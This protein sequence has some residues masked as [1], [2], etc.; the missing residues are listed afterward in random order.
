M[1]LGL[2][3]TEFNLNKCYPTIEKASEA[4]ASIISIYNNKRLH[5]SCDYLTPSQAH[6]RSGVLKKHWTNS[7]QKKVLEGMIP[8]T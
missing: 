8:T 3:K 5:A 4:V 1:T 2:L 7:Y 6:E